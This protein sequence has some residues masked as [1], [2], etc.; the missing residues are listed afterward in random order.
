MVCLSRKKN[1]MDCKNIRKNFIF[2]IENTLSKDE[3]KE[4]SEHL[5][6]CKECSGLFEEISESYRILDIK[7]EIEPKA[8]FTESV[9]GK[10]LTEESVEKESFKLDLIFSNF[11]RKISY[12]GI[13][14]IVALVI[15]FYATE[16]TFSFNF[17]AD[18]DELSTE[19]VTSLFFDN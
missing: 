8:F 4:L 1:I 6:T 2:Y 14:V 16:G 11:F 9:M 18:S 3:A 7:E 10:I 19:N 5:A 12:A 17:T 13:A 15:L